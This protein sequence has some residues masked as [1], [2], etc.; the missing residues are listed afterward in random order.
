[1]KKQYLKPSMRLFVL[2][3]RSQILCGSGENPYDDEFAYVSGRDE[4]HL[5]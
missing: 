1:M 2:N 4:H 3:G 5:A